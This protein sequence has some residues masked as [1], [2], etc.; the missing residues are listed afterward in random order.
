MFLIGSLLIS[1][2]IGEFLVRIFLKVP[3]EEKYLVFFSSNFVQ[4]PENKRDPDL[5]WKPKKINNK[6]F[7]NKADNCFRII[8]LG[9]SIT[10][11]FSSDSKPLP[12]KQTYPYKLEQL[13]RLQFKEKNIEIINA[14]NDGFSSLHGVRYLK[15]TLRE[16]HPDLV[17]CWMGINDHSSIFS[18]SDKQ[19]KVS[20]I[21]AA[22]AKPEKNRSKLYLLVKNFCLNK[23]IFNDTIDRVSSEDYYLNYEQ[24]LNVARQDAFEIVFIIPFEVSLKKNSVE[25]LRE[26]QESLEALQ[27]KYGCVI[28]D[29]SLILQSYNKKELF[30][31][32]CHPNEKGNQLIA[33]IIDDLLFDFLDEMLSRKSN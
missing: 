8:C 31:D 4:I 22:Q 24:M 14:S 33:E 2:V 21:K 32:M 23:W 30:I 1:F 26:Y 29:L 20:M 17:I 12:E 6:Y 19:Q 16:Y 18:F 13:L 9:D 5:F 28:L 10:M 15:K 25:T 11:G 27:K 3:L 7:K